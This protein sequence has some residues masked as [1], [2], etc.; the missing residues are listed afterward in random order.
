MLKKHA[1]TDL[2][3]STAEE[4]AEILFKILS[5][6]NLMMMRRQSLCSLTVQQESL[7]VVKRKTSKRAWRWLV[8]QF[9]SGA[10]YGKLKALVKASGGSL[11][12]LEELE[13]KYE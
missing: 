8:N 2:Q 11:Q 1:I 7:L 3:S 5:G 9:I 10:A 12:K 13:S 4:S 6:K